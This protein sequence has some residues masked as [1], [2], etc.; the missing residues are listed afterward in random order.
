MRRER[1]SHDTSSDASAEWARKPP[2]SG[3]ACAVDVGTVCAGVCGVSGV[4]VFV[5]VVVV[6]VVVVAAVVVVAVDVVGGGVAGDV[7]ASLLKS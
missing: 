3:P 2:A 4:S 1:G 7:V 6:D 5:V